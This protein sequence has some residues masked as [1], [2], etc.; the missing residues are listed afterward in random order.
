MFDAQQVGDALTPG[1]GELDGF[2]ELLE[3]ELG[4]DPDLAAP[5]GTDESLDDDSAGDESDPDLDTV[6]LEPRAD[7]K[8]REDDEEMEEDDGDDDFDDDEDDG[9]V[10][11]GD[12][13]DDDLDDD[14]EFEGDDD[15]EMDD[16]EDADEE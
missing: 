1:A 16:E 8:R 12:D 4:L 13:F 2:H 14:E 9:L 15:L 11:D 10:E 7:G 3:A 5:D 6:P